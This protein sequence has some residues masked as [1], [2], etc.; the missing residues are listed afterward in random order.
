MLYK[1]IEQNKRKTMWLVLSFNLLVLAIGWAI[2]YLMGG[3]MYSGVIITAIIL[4]VYI[5]FTYITANKQIIKMSGAKPV[6][7]DEYPELYN[8]VEELIIPA[9]VPMPAIYIIPDNAPNAFAAGVKPEKACVAVTQGL[10]DI[11]NREELEGVI[12][13]E[14][15]HIRNYDIRLMTISISLISVIVFISEI[16]M[17]MMFF[18]GNRKSNDNNRH[19]ALIVLAL[20]LVVLGPIAGTLIKMA[21]S[22]NREYLADASA[23]EFTRNPQ[24]LIGALNKISNTNAEVQDAKTATASM[25][26]MNPF[27]NKD[28]TGRS[29]RKKKPKANAMAT[30][31]PTSERINRLSSM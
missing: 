19:P 7:H 31:P 21:I 3:S 28:K 29:T 6:T 24:G 1:Q 26:I 8:I 12:A 15:A 23:V 20:V 4:A 17:R 13:H 11:L 14:L 30:H 10:L 16:G 9:G 5:P 22:R 18:G 25:Y 2:G 27:K